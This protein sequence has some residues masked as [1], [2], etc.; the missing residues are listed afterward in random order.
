MSAG[1][2]LS[3]LSGHRDDLFLDLFD[4]DPYAPLLPRRLVWISAIAL[5]IGLAVSP[6]VRRW[7]IDQ[8]VK[9]ATHE[10]QPLIKDLLRPSMPER[11][12]EG[13]AIPAPRS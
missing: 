6:S 9:H 4:G 5:L 1:D 10:V 11:A 12:H 7:W 2:I 3:N 8:A 13:P